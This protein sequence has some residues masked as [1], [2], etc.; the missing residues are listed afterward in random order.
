MD[1]RPEISALYQ[2]AL[3]AAKT[4]RH[5]SSILCDDAVSQRMLGDTTGAMGRWDRALVL[6]NSNP[7]ALRE[8][9]LMKLWSWEQRRNESS[10]NAVDGATEK[11]KAESPNGKEKAAGGG[12]KRRRS[13]CRGR[14]EGTMAVAAASAWL[15]LV[16]PA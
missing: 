13:K 9:A 11:V 7:R 15:N 3:E 8:H 12:P 6:D 14:P 10:E 1:R 16:V 4:D 5:K 2:R